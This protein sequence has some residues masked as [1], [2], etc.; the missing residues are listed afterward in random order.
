VK[1]KQVPGLI[2]L[3]LREHGNA[4]V[5]CQVGDHRFHLWLHPTLLQPV[6][7]VVYKNPM[8]SNG[9]HKTIKIDQRRGSGLPIATAMLAQVHALYPAARAKL[10]RELAQKQAESDASLRT[11]LARQAGPELLD[12][13]QGALRRFIS[14]GHQ[15]YP[16]VAALLAAIAKAT[17]AA[18]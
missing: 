4:T 5:Q 15:E 3:D 8:S 2:A 1:S 7:A 14:D 10:D 13:A 16:E 9:S 17:G 12:A 11:N 6:D 18:A